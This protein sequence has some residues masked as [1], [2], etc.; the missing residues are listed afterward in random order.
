MAEL[1]LADDKMCFGCG[2]ENPAGLKLSFDLDR[3]A[4]TLTTRWTPAKIHQG[5]REITH[6]GMLGLVLDEL[7]GNLLWLT[8]RPA[9]TAEMTVRFLKPLRVGETVTCQ[10]RVER[11]RGRVFWVRSKAVGSAGIV[12]EAEARCV[13]IKEKKE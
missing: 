12:A 6:G 9:V 7:M 13:H 8:G 1:E 5:Y 4:G 11:E 3:E 2:R 10:A